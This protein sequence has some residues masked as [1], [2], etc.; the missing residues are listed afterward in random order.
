MGSS[1]PVALALHPN[2][3]LAPGFPRGR[4][5]TTYVVT[6]QRRGICVTG[7]RTITKAYSNRCTGESEKE[8]RRENGA[9]ADEVRW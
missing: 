1:T 3:E 7:P 8:A 2:V 5:H 4:V 6:Y 9:V